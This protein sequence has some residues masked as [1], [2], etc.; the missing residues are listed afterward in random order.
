[1]SVILDVYRLEG[2]PKWTADVYAGGAIVYRQ[3]RLTRIDAM[4]D[5]L[6]EIDLRYPGAQIELSG[7]YLG[8]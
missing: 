1:M 5:A 3:Q 6:R 2:E 4:I 7:N 8:E